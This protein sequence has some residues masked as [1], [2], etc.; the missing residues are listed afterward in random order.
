MNFPK[1]NDDF[2]SSPLQDSGS[3]FDSWAKWQKPAKNQIEKLVKLTGHTYSC[4]SF[5]D[6][7]Y[8]A[9]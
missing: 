7:E 3:K 5:K 8:E 1:E 9:M 6:F 4:N 2:S